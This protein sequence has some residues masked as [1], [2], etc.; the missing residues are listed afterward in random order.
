MPTI[1]SV[2]SLTPE[3]LKAAAKEKIQTALSSAGL[4]IDLREGSYTDALISECAYLVYRSIQY[5][6]S[7]MDAAVP[8]PDGG[9]YL[10]AFAK[11]FST[12]VSSN[13][14]YFL[15]NGGC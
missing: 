1:P 12:N 13:S 2:A 7:L 11:T 4:S 8:G 9:P 14:G 15:I 10:D 3:S 6:R 5:S